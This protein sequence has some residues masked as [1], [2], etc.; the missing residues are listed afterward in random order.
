MMVVLFFV[1]FSSIA[2]FPSE[3]P[4]VQRSDVHRHEDV[5]SDVY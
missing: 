4:K 2:M 1:I 5:H 3:E